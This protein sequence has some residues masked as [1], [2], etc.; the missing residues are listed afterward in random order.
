MILGLLQ[1]RMSSSRLP[2][3][4]LAPLLG[5]PM[6]AQQL[7]RLGRAESLDR[8]VVATSSDASD[9]AVATLCAELGVGCFR[10]SLPDVLDRF[11][12]AAEH[13]GPSQ[14][15]V[16]LT[17]DCPLIDPQLVDLLVAFHLECGF[18]YAANCRPPT[19]PDGLDA[20]VFT[21]EALAQAWAQA[22]DPFEREHVVPYIIRRPELFSLGNWSLEAEDYSGLR[23]TVDEPEDLAFVR[24][25]YEALYPENPCFGWRDVLELLSRRPELRDAS[26]RYERN[27][28]SMPRREYGQ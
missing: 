1:A 5:R 2:G 25:V 13:F 3:K 4:V 14:H 15:V 9:D 8:L 11:Y 27:A 21:M 17:G 6:L 12:R 7:E 18:D 22:Q 23:W 26:D 20:E 16:R 28:G 24:R 19:L 10:G